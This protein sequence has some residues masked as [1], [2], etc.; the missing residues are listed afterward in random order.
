MNKLISVLL[1]VFCVFLFISGIE[2]AVGQ[3]ADFALDAI[4]ILA[5]G[6]DNPRNSEGDFAILKEGRILFVFTQYNGN[7]TSDHAPAGLAAI[8]SSDNGTTWTEPRIVLRQDGGL[9]IMS[10]SLLRLSDNR[11]ALFY[12]RKYSAQDCR[13]FVCYSE[14]EGQTWTA[15]GPCITDQIGYYVVNN[16]RVVQLSDG[17]LLIPTALHN[18]DTERFNPNAKMFCYR[19][20]DLGK[21]W[22]RTGEAANP[23]KVVFQEPG[24]VELADGRVLMYIRTNGGCQYLSWSSDKGETWSEAQ[25]SDFVSPMSPMSIAPLPGSDKLL[26]VWN[27][28]PNQRD[29][30]TLAIV[31]MKL[32][33]QR[34]WDI[35]RSVDANGTVINGGEPRW[36]CYPAILPLTSDLQKSGQTGQALI[37]YCAGLKKNWG[38]DTTKIVRVRWN[39]KSPEISPEVR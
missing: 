39:I 5:P 26:C 30:L 29:P 14:N 1:Y 10:V 33:V 8:E 23:G 18:T 7:S 35:D 12:L 13:P 34:R 6:A 9:N 17:T 4:K 28:S 36:F 19:S 24:L 11:L 20:D 2:R 3:G 38:L 16:S 22:R 15:P 37:A 27:N 31:N 25:R 32:E 21:T